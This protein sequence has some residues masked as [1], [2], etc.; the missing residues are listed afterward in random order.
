MILFCLDCL[1]AG[2]ADI[3][4][5][6]RSDSCYLQVFIGSFEREMV[7][8]ASKHFCSRGGEKEIMCEAS[9]PPSGSKNL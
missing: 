3:D 8:F 1:A 6:Y 4:K 9:G 2:R 7:V 5:H